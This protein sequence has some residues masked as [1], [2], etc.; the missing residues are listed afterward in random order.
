MKHRS[1]FYTSML[2][3]LGLMALLALSACGGKDTPAGLIA[4]GKD[5]A[6]K[7]D[8]KA[9]VV[10][11]KS[12]LQGDPSLVEAR[13][14]LGQSLLASGDGAGASV[15]LAKAMDQQ[16]DE[17]KVVPLLAR[18][19]LSTGEHRKLTTQFADRQ[20]SDKTAQA[21]LKVVLARAWATLGDGAKSEASLAAALAGAPEYG[22]ALLLRAQLLAGK[23]DFDGAIALA[24]AILARDPN[25]L[26]AWLLKGDLFAYGKLDDVSARQAYRKVLDNDKS[27]V[28]AYL[29]LISLELRAKNLAAAKAEADKL[30]AL[31]PGHGQVIYVDAQIA[32]AERKVPKARELVQQ[33]LRLTSDHTGVL[34]LAGAIDAELGLLVQAQS[35]LTKAL[36][37]DPGLR[38]ARQ[39]LARVY[40]RLSQPKK[41]L[42]VLQP[43]LAEGSTD[44]EA[45]A[46]AGE[47]Q[48]RLGD[49]AAAEASF[50][51]AAKINPDDSRVMTALA[52]SRI[53]RGDSISAF[54][55]LETASARTKDLYVDRAIVAARLRR[56]EF[57]AALATIAAMEKKQPN[58]ATVIELRGNVQL[59]R[60][61]YASARRAYE[62]ALQ[63]DPALFSA[64]ANLSAI[65]VIE[66]KTDAARERLE[67]YIKSNPQNPYSLASLAELKIQTGAPL[68]EVRALLDSAIKVAP[69][70]PLMRLQ[71]MELLIRKRLYKDAL[72]AAQDAA[73]A[74]PND[75]AIM[76]A[77]GRSQMEA[78]DIEQAIGTFRKLAGIDGN[79]ARAYARLA[80]IYKATGKRSQAESALRK[81]IELEPGLGP[82]QVALVDLLVKDKREADALEFA[83]RV[84]RDSK[85]TATGWLLEA[86]VHSRMKDQRAAIEALRTGLNKRPKDLDLTRELYRRLTFAGRTAEADRLAADWMKARPKDYEFEYMVGINRLGRGD[87]AQA[88]IHL[89]SVVAQQPSHA[90]SLNNLAAALVAQGKPGATEFAQRAV[91]AAPDQPQ[92]LDTLALALAAEK[93]FD[94]ALSTQRQAVKLAPEDNALRLHLAKIALDSGDKALAKQELTRLRELGSKFALQAEVEKLFKSL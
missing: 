31:L 30:R 19:W 8:H 17:N 60:R 88:E 77:V 87:L 13:L 92:V 70:E 54:S 68:E 90:L 22:P 1:T 45:F 58:T 36:Q 64:V 49:A 89:R 24:N 55:E 75:S 69:T 83:R 91:D 94:L 29:S 47:A 35:L 50:V 20:L 14:L 11:F 16:A 3:A 4:S 38:S 26:E 85:N 72:A 37:I 2:K 15:E 32:Y 74:M 43:Q 23:R 61:D 39:N 66:K 21:A 67:R 10:Q 48:Q 5:Y 79:G 40:L 81:A 93:K 18:A 53:S 44:A 51:R 28:I 33:V 9:A 56:N 82:A 71:L 62:E 76:D 7:K 59:M 27:N 12:A 65:D 42:D 46:L 41:A 73:A 57:D 63:R 84:Q 80:D 25:L 52:L 86:M 34:Q 78:G 6:A